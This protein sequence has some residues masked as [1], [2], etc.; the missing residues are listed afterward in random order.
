MNQA[1]EGISENTRGAIDL[2]NFG[3]A[4]G[5]APAGLHS[6]I[7]VANVNDFVYQSAGKILTSTGGIQNSPG[8]I[9]GNLQ[10]PGSYQF[11]ETNFVVANGVVPVQGDYNHSW[12]YY[13]ADPTTR[14]AF[15]LAPLSQDLADYYHHSMWVQEE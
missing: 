11:I 10:N 6:Y 12:Q 9:E 2:R 14:E 4:V 1:I 5:T 3:L 8:F 15:G 7:G 13:M